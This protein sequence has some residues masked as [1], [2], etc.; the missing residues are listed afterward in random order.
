M[1]LA[2]AAISVA[3]VT[4]LRGYVTTQ[5]DNNLKAAVYPDFSNGT[6][7]TLGSGPRAQSIRPATPT[8]PTRT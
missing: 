3:S 6:L 5:Q 8:R 7:P 2:L 4:M 1:I